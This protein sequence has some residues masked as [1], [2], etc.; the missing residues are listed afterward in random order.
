MHGPQHLCTFLCWFN[1]CHASDR[2]VRQ[3]FLI[4]RN[5]FIIKTHAI[6]LS[7]DGYLAHN[8]IKYYYWITSELE[9]EFSIWRSFIYSF[10]L[11][12]N[13]VEHAF[14]GSI[15]IFIF[16]IWFDRRQSSLFAIRSCLQEQTIGALSGARTM[17]SIRCPRHLHAIAAAR[18]TISYTKTF[19][20]T[21]FPFVCHNPRRRQ[22]MSWL[23]FDIL[24]RS[25]KS[26]NLRCDACSAGACKRNIIHFWA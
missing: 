23:Q 6:R 19:D 8:H 14:H 26:K 21:A 22:T 18:L 20:R 13:T 16:V 5:N 11:L 15:T 24:R 17:E 1:F 25:S 12:I 9:L 3:P 4:Y 7:L 10:I 2:S